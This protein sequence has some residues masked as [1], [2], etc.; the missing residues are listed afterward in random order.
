MPRHTNVLPNAHFHKDWQERVRTWFDQPARKQRRRQARLK[1]AARIFPRPIQGALRPVVHPPTVKYNMKV[2]LGRGFTLE[3]LKEAGINRHTA[4][5]IG[6]A[7][8]HRRRNRS[9]KSFKTNVQRLKEYRSKLIL[10]P[11]DKKHPK[12]GEATAEDQAKPEQQTGVLLPIKPRSAKLEVVNLADIDP[13][14]SAYAT[15]RKARSDARL[16]GVRALRA[17]KK[18]E[19]AAL[20]SQKAA[21]GKQ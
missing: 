1:K 11:R 3:E 4:L 18:A 9:D 10:F 13:K 15:L 20:E 19:E 5:T 21:K 16:I 14:Q 12:S 7:V 6:V 2:R 17:K 8:D